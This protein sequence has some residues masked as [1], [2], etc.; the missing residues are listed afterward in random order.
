MENRMITCSI[1]GFLATAAL[2]VPAAQAGPAPAA[3]IARPSNPGGPGE[4]ATLTG[5]AKA[6][7]KIFA[8]NCMPCHG[9]QGKGGIPNPGSTDGTVPPLNPI[10]ITMVSKDPKVFAHN[11]DLFIQNGSTPDGHNPAIKMPAW[12]ADKMLKQQQ[13]A[14]LIAYIISL[15]PAK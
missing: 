1:L 13:I 10:D 15:N 3:A 8:T 9:N 14:D 12:G 2:A 4:A 5:D 6:G 11:I 7:A